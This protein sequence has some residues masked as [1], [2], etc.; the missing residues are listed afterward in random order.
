MVRKNL[1]QIFM[2]AKSEFLSWIT[3][4]R[5]IIVGILLIFMKAIIIT[6]LAARADKFGDKLIIFEPFIS[7]GN[8]SVLLLFIPFT[9][10]VLLSDYPRLEGNTLF[11]IS[12][13]G[14]RNWFLGQL[15]FIFAAVFVFLLFVMLSSILLA[16]GRFDTSWSD[17]VTKYNA[18]FPNEAFNFDSL[19]LPS[20]LYNQ[21]SMIPALIETFL[22]LAAY[23][24][25][26]SLIIYLFKIMFNSG[27][28]GLIS[29]LTVLG[30][31]LVTYSINSDLRWAFPMANAIVCSHYEV[32]S[33]HPVYPMWCSY[34]YFGILIPI[35]IIMN[36]IA[37]KRMKLTE[38][39]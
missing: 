22:F 25:V 17:A 26:L 18:R 3:N 29:G 21:I 14:K 10:L 24:I 16:G 20:N 32:I 9:F 33:S 2:I 7:V 36:L 13:T 35:L 34:L 11:F 8:S 15:L 39:Y 28:V 12:R 31:G 38:N 23:L 27:T 1:K 19:L 4:P 6:P 37:I 30:L 5:I